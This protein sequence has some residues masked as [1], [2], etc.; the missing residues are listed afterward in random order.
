MPKFQ[1][2]TKGKKK[3]RF[4][5]AADYDVNNATLNIGVGKAHSKFPFSKKLGRE[6]ATSRLVKKPIVVPVHPEQDIREVYKNFVDNYISNVKTVG[7]E[8]NYS[9]MRAFFQPQIAVANV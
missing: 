6:I 8:Y 9:K 1:H 2:F 7:G 4:T 5:F 3:H